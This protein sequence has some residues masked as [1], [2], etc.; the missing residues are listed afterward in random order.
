[1]EEMRRSSVLGD[2]LVQGAKAPLKG[3]AALVTSPVRTS[4]SIVRGTGRFFGNLGHSLYSDDPAQDNALEVILGY[5]AA[6]RSFAYELG[7]NPYTRYEPAAQRLG[8]IARAA[9]AGGIVPSTLLATVDFSGASAVR[10]SGTADGMRQLARDNPPGA[11]RGINRRKLIAMG[12]DEDLADAFLDNFGFD[13]LEETLLVGALEG[14]PKAAG[15]RYMVANASL[16][17]DPASARMNRVI[18]QMMAAYYERVTEE[19]SIVDAGGAVGLRRSD[20]TLVLMAPVDRIFWTRPVAD[21]LA[22]LAE[23]LADGPGFSRRELWVAGDVDGEARE[24]FEEAG[25]RIRE[26]ARDVLSS[27]PEGN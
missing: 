25:W 10:L 26:H 20:G 3:A 7:V 2:A 13:P 17:A 27:E 19:V 4:R 5:D 6:K 14:M 8:E 1:M 24:R 16:A 12:I 18:A 9:V 15:R 23:E 22:L 11:L 21:N